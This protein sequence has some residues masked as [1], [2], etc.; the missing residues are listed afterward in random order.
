MK[1]LNTDISDEKKKTLI[2]SKHDQIKSK[3]TKL[4][5]VVIIA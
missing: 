2:W 1:K 4:D 5:L 3:M